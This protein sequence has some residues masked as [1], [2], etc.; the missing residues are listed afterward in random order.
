MKKKK[1]DH[2]LSEENILNRLLKE[3]K[4]HKKIV[5]GFDF[6]NTVYDYHKENQSYEMVIDLLRRC[7]KHGF[8]L[9]VFTGSESSRY[10][11]IKKYLNENNIP[12][13]KI[14]EN[15]SFFKSDS[16]KIF[17]NI[18]LDDRAGLPS[19]YNIL[20]KLLKIIENEKI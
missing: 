13:D 14:N 16:R 6:D 18:L 19:A 12:F 4:L 8:E 3:Y 20:I 17:Y 9:I 10:E 2:F 7:K 5:I 1:I 11:F 15:P